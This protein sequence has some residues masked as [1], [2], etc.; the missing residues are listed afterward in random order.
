MED[1]HQ[2]SKNRADVQVKYDSFNSALNQILS[3][4]TTSSNTNALAGN[5][6]NPSVDYNMHGL[7]PQ[8]ASYQQHLVS[9]HHSN[10]SVI[11]PTQVSNLRAAGIDE[12][13]LILQN[14]MNSNPGQNN[15]SKFDYM[16]NQLNIPANKIHGQAPNR[17]ITPPMT[18]NQM[19]PIN[20]Q[21]QQQQQQQ[22]Q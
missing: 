8:M 22:Q 14:Q 4:D 13:Y 7:N 16:A 20:L 2:K 6:N 11:D 3:S 12:N 5:I 21:Q 1:S 17:Q 9:R 18:V 10:K 15:N 19:M